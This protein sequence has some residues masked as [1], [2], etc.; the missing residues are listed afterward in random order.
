MGVRIISNGSCAVLYCSTSDWAFGP[1]FYEDED[2]TAEE[3]AEKFLEWLPQDARLY[4]D[5]DLQFKYTEW[6]AEEAKS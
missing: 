5:H 3:R 1:I 6:L 4:D 2:I